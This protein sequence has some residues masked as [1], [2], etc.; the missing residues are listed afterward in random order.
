MQIAVDN[1]LL[2]VMKYFTDY[3]L[4]DK[5][6]FDGILEYAQQ[7]KAMEIVALLL[8]YRGEDNRITAFDKYEL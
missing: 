1:S 8:K 7:K 5:D 6:I 2:N 3:K 4:F